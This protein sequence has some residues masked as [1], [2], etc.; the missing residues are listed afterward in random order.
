MPTNILRARSPKPTPP[1]P[2]ARPRRE[3]VITAGSV[4]VR[5]VLLAT[6]TADRIWT[7]LPI[8]STAETWG[9]CIHFETPVETGRERGAKRTVAAG[10]VCYWS[11]DDRVIIAFGPTPISGAGE[12]RL[13]SPCN[14]WAR[15]LDD[16]AALAAVTPGERA[17]IVR[18]AG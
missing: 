3:V 18:T 10:E 7:A 16:V 15:A 1:S 9:D 13:P 17:S 5:A 8:H 11:E 2:R 6:T 4:R 12:I 14:V